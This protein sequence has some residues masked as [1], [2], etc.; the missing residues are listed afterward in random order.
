MSTQPTTAVSG[1]ARKRRF[2][3][4]AE[5]ADYLN[6]S[7]PTVYRL[8]HENILPSVKFGKARRIAWD[9]VD[10]FVERSVVSE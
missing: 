5:V 7:R 1:G 10:Q 8:M 9:A 3:K 2:G 4:V 6:L